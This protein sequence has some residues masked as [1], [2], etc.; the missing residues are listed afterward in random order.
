[1][2]DNLFNFVEKLVMNYEM[3]KASMCYVNANLHLSLETR[4]ITCALILFHP[5]EYMILF[6]HIWKHY[7]NNKS[8]IMII[9]RLGDQ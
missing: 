4:V 1:M 2:C 6:I 7:C 8:V 3:F 9:I 5:H